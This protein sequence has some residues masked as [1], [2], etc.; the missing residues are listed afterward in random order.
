MARSR[1]ST[2]AIALHWA[3]AALIII[4]LAVG[5]VME[6]YPPGVRGV[7]VGSHATAGLTVLLL[8]V[9]RVLWR[10]RHS[11]P[12][13]PAD[14]P[15]WERSAAHLA[16]CLLYALMLAMPLIGW[17]ILSAH[18]ARPGHGIPLLGS[19][20]MLPIGF[21][22]HWPAAFQKM[23]HDRFVRLHVIGAW[24]LF[25]LLL[26]HIAGALKHQLIDGHAELA[27]MGLGRLRAH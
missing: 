1:Y 19:L 8:S 21:I 10:L 7:L 15:R 22:S 16:H 14:M 2:V 25:G 13:L 12:P 27:R 11:P 6:S 3:I 18:P 5:S 17:S 26:L 9:L 23:M 24:L 20:Q 4:D